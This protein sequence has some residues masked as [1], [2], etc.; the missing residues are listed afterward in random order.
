MRCPICKKPVEE[1]PEGIPLPA[2]F[3]FCG[4]R[5]KLIDLGRW[6]DGKY[7]IPVEEPDPTDEENGDGE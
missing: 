4:D 6:L 3:P 7:Q 2:C 1:P 5:C